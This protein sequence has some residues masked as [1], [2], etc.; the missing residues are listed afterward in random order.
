V[1]P[2]WRKVLR[3]ASLHK[4]RTLLA[5]LALATGLTGSGALLDTW[6]LVRRATAETYLASLPVS[7]TLRV[8][9]TDGGTL[10]AIRAHPKIAAVHARRVALGT[11]VAENG[12]VP[13]LLFAPDAFDATDMALL[14]LTSGHWP[15][16]GEVAIEGSSLDLS[17]ASVGE[18][19]RVRAGTGEASALRVV[20]V[21][22]DVSVAPGWMDHVVYG[23]VTAA[24]LRQM[25]TGSQEIQF[26]V[27]DPAPAR[28]DVREVASEVRALIVKAGIR[29]SSVNVPVPNQ[30]VHAAQMDSLLLT[31]GAFAILALVACA[32]LVV[33]LMAALLAGQ[34][35]EIAVMKAVGASPRQLFAMYLAFAAALGLAAAAISL[36]LGSAIARPYAALKGQMLNFPVEGFSIPAW[37]FVLQAIA[38]ALVPVAAAAFT[39]A[40]ACRASVA[41]SL[42]DGAAG[43]DRLVT[44]RVAIPGIGRP[45]ML[46]LNNALRRRGRLALTLATLAAGG[47]VFV[48]AHNLRTSVIASV[49]SM[50]EGFRQDFLLRVADPRPAS[51]LEAAVRL[52]EGVASAEAWGTATA[53]AP[54]PG[55]TPGENFAVLAMPVPSALMSPRIVAGRWLERDDER[56]LVATRTLLAND[57]RF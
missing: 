7:A 32:L 37:A 29:V 17:K 25:G 4:G 42:R 54:Q 43:G 28:E 53:N 30:H 12:E 40:R 31:Q 3:D 35:R 56:A 33:N 15:S 1:S 45:L 9:R 27:R 44:H 8:D 24:T 51:R 6:S 11:L 36:P 18:A 41:Q 38:G 10:A 57:A 48:A 50:F 26:R 55:G 2:R 13:A 14:A 47:A 23:F 20:G 46:S 39:V 21:A 16:D 5:I 19:I 34:S 52:A 49:D 22:H